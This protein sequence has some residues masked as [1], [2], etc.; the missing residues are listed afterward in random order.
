MGGVE[1]V[2]VGLIGR[3]RQREP[4]HTGEGQHVEE[5]HQADHD[6]HEHQRERP[7]LASDDHVGRREKQD[8]REHDHHRAVQR[9]YVPGEGQGAVR[10]ERA[11]H[12]HQHEERGRQQGQQ[13]TTADP[14]QAPDRAA[15][16]CGEKGRDRHAR[17]MRRGPPKRC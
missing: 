15:A 2:D 8:N 13:S 17:N 10:Q 3:E 5:P 11:E 12:R 14:F 7:A 16:R 9:G 1:E 6:A 4:N